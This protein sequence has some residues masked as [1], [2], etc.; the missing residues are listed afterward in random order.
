MKTALLYFQMNEIRGT[1]F[2]WVPL[3]KDLNG[4]PCVG[5]ADGGGSWCSI[6]HT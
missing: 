1:F 3:W 4:S 2:S 6:M 5:V